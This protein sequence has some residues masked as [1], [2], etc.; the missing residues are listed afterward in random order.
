MNFMAD[1]DIK[2][3][4]GKNITEYLHL[5]GEAMCGPFAPYAEE[6]YNL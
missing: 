3:A 1:S 6:E 2:N 4:D 5:A